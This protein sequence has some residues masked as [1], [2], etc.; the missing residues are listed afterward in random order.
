M[1]CFRTHVTTVH[2][3][4]PEFV[5]EKNK[6]IIIDPFFGKDW[7]LCFNMTMMKMFWG[8]YVPRL[9]PFISVLVL[10]ER[11]KHV[12][13]ECETSRELVIL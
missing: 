9:L 4:P 1:F 13:V 10:T 6:N 12:P 7:L 8:R 11:T 5:V 2:T 3:A